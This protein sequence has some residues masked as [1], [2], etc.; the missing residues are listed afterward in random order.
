MNRVGIQRSA[1]I[2]LAGG[3]A[4][5]ILGS[6]WAADVAETDRIGNESA[7]DGPGNTDDDGHDQPARVIS[8]H[9]ELCDETGNQ[10]KNYPGQN[11]HNTLRSFSAK[12]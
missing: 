4:L 10:A 6:R 12:P 8:R 3:L 2:L 9:H 1:I 7:N 11:I 5:T